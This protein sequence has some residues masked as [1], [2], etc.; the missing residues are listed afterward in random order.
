MDLRGKFVGED[1]LR[2]ARE[3]RRMSDW[4][5][6]LD[7]AVRGITQERILTRRFSP[8]T[9][10]ICA[11]PLLVAG[12]RLVRPAP[13]IQQ[14]GRDPARSRLHTRSRFRLR[15]RRA[16]CQKRRCRKNAWR[17]RADGHAP[18]QSDERINLHATEHSPAIF[19]PDSRGKAP[20]SF[21]LPNSTFLRPS[22]A[23]DPRTPRR[24]SGF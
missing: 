7:A 13:R 24:L 9:L 6:R 17:S 15:R 11:L 19:V 16:P 14:A 12:F 20:S 2:V 4:P 18:K 22:F 23:P 3:P 10:L 1:A 5:T 8:W 21:F